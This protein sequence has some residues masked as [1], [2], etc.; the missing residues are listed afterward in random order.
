MRP[1]PPREASD[2]ATT[3]PEWRADGLRFFAYGHHLK[4]KFGQ[5][6]QKVSLDA[7]FVCPNVD[8]TVAYGGCVFCDIKS[9]SPSR[10]QAFRGGIAEQLAHGMARVRSR[11]KKCDA[12]IA[13]FQPSTN[14]RVQA[15]KL[16]DLIG[17]VFAEPAVRGVAVSARPDCLA[18]DILEVLADA[19][20]EHYVVVELG[21][22]SIHDESLAWM[23]RGHDAECSRVATRRCRELGLEVT[24]HVIL[25]LPRR[26]NRQ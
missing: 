11:Y 1:C 14:T 17:A 5:R 22:Q 19:A 9:F 23:N 4:R 13:Y 7:G 26:R 10:R 24:G 18:D 16:Q 21:I 15:H 3:P 25:G 2:A 12:F 8:G 20:R 6:V